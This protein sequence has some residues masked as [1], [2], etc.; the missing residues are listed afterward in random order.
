M[1]K[2]WKRMISVL[3]VACMAVGFTAC[4]DDAVTAYEIA[5]KNG[6][7][8]TEAEWLASLKG[9]DGT[10]GNDLTIEDLY[11]AAKTEGFEGS[12]LEF[13]QSLGVE[14]K[15]NNDTD[16]SISAN[17]LFIIYRPPPRRH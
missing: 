6:F 8:G 15:E 14:V 13:I 7:T 16:K 12:L 3:C 10:D 5:K 2:I 1:K 11:E 17:V 4:K 9:A